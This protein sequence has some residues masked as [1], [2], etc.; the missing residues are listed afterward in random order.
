MPADIA[1]RTDIESLLTKFYERAF[2]DDVI[3][4]IFTEITH[5]D[6]ATHLPVIA[7]FWEDILLGTHHYHGNPVKV[8]L[9]IDRLSELNENQ[10]NRW[11][12]LWQITVDRYFTGPI[13]DE[14]RH[15]A[16]NIAK[17]MIAKILQKR[18]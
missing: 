16:N 14:A 2:A 3:G 8:H 13:A 4:F 5:L 10:F 1:S 11:L 17:V 12:F 18:Q 7:N 6:L 9:E 15:R